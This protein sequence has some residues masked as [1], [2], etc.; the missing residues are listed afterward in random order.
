MQL[1]KNVLSGWG[2]L[3]LNFFIILILTPYVIS[4]LGQEQ[5]GLWALILSII[6]FYNLADL[7]IQSATRRYFAQ[8]IGKKSVA[9][10]N[11]TYS[12]VFYIFLS[13]GIILLLLSLILAYLIPIFFEVNPAYEKTFPV[14]LL[15]LGLNTSLVFISKPFGGILA[16]NERYDIVNIVEI[17]G[18]IIQGGLFFLVLYMGY[19]IVAMSCVLIIITI[20]KFS[21][22][23]YLVK[24]SFSE[25]KLKNSLVNK[26]FIKKLF[27]YSIISFVLAFCDYLRVQL[28]IILVGKFI[29][30]STVA[31]YAIATQFILYLT[32]ASRTISATYVSRLSR[33]EGE[34]NWDEIQKQFLT[35][36]RYTSTLVLFL[37]ASIIIFGRQFIYLWLGAEFDISYLILVILIA[38][39]TFTLTQSET[40]S[41]FYATDNHKTYAKFT[42]IETIINI[43]VSISLIP[44]Y[45]VYGIA[46]G[47]FVSAISLKLFIQP[48]FACK[49]A[50]LRYRDLL[51][52]GFGRPALFVLTY[53]LCV[54][55]IYYYSHTSVTL[56]SFII[57]VILASTVGF[58][59]A[60]FIMLKPD[61]RENIRARF[62]ARIAS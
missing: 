28:D 56:H 54:L 1:L 11:E 48:N 42:I 32:L 33:L 6:G 51:I 46:L 58:I 41:L 60:Y 21:L 50:K 39:N 20:I 13:I 43:T 7:G 47:T 37:A 30:I 36:T 8:S 38:G 53:T 10:Q 19:G 2:N 4:Q 57:S 31:F 17:I 35:G 24:R 23:F 9:L 5:Y 3:V 55:P 40:V 34:N 29:S 15:L 27:N 25:L 49:I 26:L 52:R 61:E 62:F 45:G 22:E 12:N 18:S 59:S 14:T 44:Y 16:A